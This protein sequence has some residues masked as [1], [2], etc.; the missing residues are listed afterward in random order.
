[1][2]V[3]QGSRHIAVLS[4]VHG[5]LIALRA[6]L[7]D[8]AALGIDSVVVAGD[9]VNFGPDPDDV[10]DLLA[11]QGA[12][13]IRGNHEQVFVA[14]YGTDEM[15]ASWR[16]NLLT[17]CWTM[18]RLG[19]Q[20]R[21]LLTALPDRL[22]IDAT[23]LVVHGSPRHVRDSVLVSTPTEELDAMF[24]GEAAR[25][26]FVGHTHRAAVRQTPSRTVINVGSVGFPM[27][28]DP[29]AAYAV[30]T[31]QGHERTETWSVSIRRVPFDVEQAIAAY[32][33]GCGEAD[34]IFATIMARMLRTG[35]DY[36]GPW[37]RVS[38]GLAHHELQGALMDYLAAN[39]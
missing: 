31:R 36:L 7:A 3:P 29:R 1:M 13:M 17:M 11:A 26:A 10:V 9:M 14:L 18:E 21:A 35:R 24:A 2:A 12:Q 5:N 28:G 25:L 34:L 37:V 22:M 32:D 8:V 27:D 4:D 30:A 19:V 39:P 15:P 6:V 23:T 16:T 33:N 38:A 20:R